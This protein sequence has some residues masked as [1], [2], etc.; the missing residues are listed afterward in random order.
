MAE[1]GEQGRGRQ[2]S[3]GKA[4]R[5]TEGEKQRSE[6]EEEETERREP[7]GGGKKKRREEEEQKKER[8]GGHRSRGLEDTGDITAPSW[9]RP[10]TELK[11]CKRKHCGHLVDW[12]ECQRFRIRPPRFLV[13]LP[14]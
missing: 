9:L 10:H 7:V 3:V 5:R 13:Q 14:P 2:R 12:D 11:C 1:R 4:A 6:G 8:R